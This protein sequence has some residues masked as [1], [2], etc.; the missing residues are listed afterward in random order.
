MDWVGE[1]LEE[2]IIQVH[3]NGGPPKMMA[4][5]PAVGFGNAE[6]LALAEN[7]PEVQHVIEGRRHLEMFPMMITQI[8]RKQCLA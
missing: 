8:R 3:A 2:S 5:L 6:L 7:A 4:H 1:K